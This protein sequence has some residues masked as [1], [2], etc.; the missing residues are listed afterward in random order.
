M[1]WKKEYLEPIMKACH[2]N[3][4]FDLAKQAR[5][6]ERTSDYQRIAAYSKQF[7]DDELLLSKTLLTEIWNRLENIKNYANRY[8]V[9]N[10][11]LTQ[12]IDDVWNQKQQQYN[13]WKD[14]SQSQ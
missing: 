13:L 2:R 14:S 5:D 9:M 3:Y 12:F 6:I 11:C 10:N 4:T 7:A 8:D 1:Q